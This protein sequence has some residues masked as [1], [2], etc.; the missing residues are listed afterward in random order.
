LQKGTRQEGC[1][2]IVHLEGRRFSGSCGV[3]PFLRDCKR[4]AREDGLDRSVILVAAAGER[5]RDGG[6]RA[7]S[8]FSFAHP[9]FVLLSVGYREGTH[10]LARLILP[11]FQI[12]VIDAL[13]SPKRPHGAAGS[14]AGMDCGTAL[15]KSRTNR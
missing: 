5:V 12:H 11:I 2:I 3:P 15:P 1:A 6:P 4:L 14:E 10:V 8:P 13:G 9:I 7:F